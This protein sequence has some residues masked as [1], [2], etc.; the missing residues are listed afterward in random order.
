MPCFERRHVASHSPQAREV[1]PFVPSTI[2]ARLL[3]ERVQPSGQ[4]QESTYLF[5]ENAAMTSNGMTE[6]AEHCLVSKDELPYH[7]YVHAERISI[8]MG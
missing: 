2:H 8:R 4:D 6:T 5:C 7:A 1:W 3:A